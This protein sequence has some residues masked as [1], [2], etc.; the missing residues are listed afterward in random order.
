LRDVAGRIAIPQ[1]GVREPEDPTLEPPDERGGRLRVVGPQPG[2]QR[3]IGQ[4]HGIST[5]RNRGE[6]PPDST[7]VIWMLRRSEPG[8]SSPI[9]STVTDANAS[10]LP[11]RNNPPLA[12]TVTETVC[13]SPSHAVGAMDPVPA[14]GVW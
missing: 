7:Y 5:H 8:N 4:R 14:T 3:L 10:A 6:I 13:G 11:A 9:S 12:K 1:H 2:Q